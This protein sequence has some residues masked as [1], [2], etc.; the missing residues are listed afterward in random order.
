LRTK[1][2]ILVS[3][4]GGAALLPLIGCAAAG[5]SYSPAERRDLR[6]RALDLLLAG[7]QSP[8]DDV[9]ANALEALTIAAP[10]EGVP[11]FRDAVRSDRPLVR[12]AGLVSLGKVRDRASLGLA[13]AALS[14]SDPLVR[15]AA[16]FAGLRMG[17][18]SGKFAP[19]LADT[20]A[21]HP[22]RTCGPKPPT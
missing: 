5:P 22:T 14:D 7:T 10:D 1:P 11:A 2:L 3:L 18:S 19:L 9:A 16:A 15:L 4:I 6:S 21:N 20:L 12:F 8:F 17:G 13:E